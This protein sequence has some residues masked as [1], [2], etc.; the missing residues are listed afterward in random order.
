MSGASLGSDPD[1]SR[2]SY[3]T[4]TKLCGLPSLVDQTSGDYAKR[5]DWLASEVLLCLSAVRF[6]MFPPN[7]DSRYG[8]APEPG[9]EK[10]KRYDCR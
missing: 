10:Q 4:R 3:G 5:I 7:C 9:K 8:S 6:D 1:S 2:V